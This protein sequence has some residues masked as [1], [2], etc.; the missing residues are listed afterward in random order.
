MITHIVLFWTD[1]QDEEARAAVQEGA[2]RLLAD[3]P[4]ALNFRSGAA[5]PSERGVVDDTYAAAIC[6]DF[7][8]QADM[9]AYLEHP[10]HQ[11]FVSK[12]VKPHV[13]RYIVY[14]IAS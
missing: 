13:K 10:Q 7:K 5:F 3:I 12:C 11:E 2:K 1:K 8:T 14:D 6:M 9:Q 4:G